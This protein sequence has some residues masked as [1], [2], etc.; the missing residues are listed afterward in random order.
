MVNYFVESSF[1]PFLSVSLSLSLSLF[2]FPV[3][4]DLNHNDTKQPVQ[5]VGGQ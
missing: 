2:L 1:S 3:S 5:L 4:F